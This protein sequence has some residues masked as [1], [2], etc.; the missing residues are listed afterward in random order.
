MPLLDELASYL[1]SRGVGVVG[2]DLFKGG[3]PD[4]PTLP[5]PDPVVGLVEYAS[6]PP[7]RVHGP[8]GAV[9]TLAEQPR[10]QVLVRSASYATAR[11]R[12]QAVVAALD[13]LGPMTLT[14]SSGGGTR[15]AQVEVLQ[16]PPVP[17]DVDATGRWRFAV[18]VTA[19]R[20]A[21]A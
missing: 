5:L 18:N 13:W 7:L 17:L 6:G 8:T 12:A 11:L 9:A 2:A 1:A 4:A 10:V 15:Y 20:A 21:D 16:R 3:L 14:A 19:V